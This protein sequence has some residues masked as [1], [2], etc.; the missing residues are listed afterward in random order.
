MMVSAGE[1]VR[2]RHNDAPR[3]VVTADDFGLSSTVNEGIVVASRR[4]IVRNTAL[5]VNFA[6]VAASVASLRDAGDLDVGIHLNLTSGPPVSKADQVPSLLGRGGTFPGLPGF[7]ARAALGRIR[8]G[9]VRREWE[10]QIEL[11]IRLGCRFTS[12]SGHQHVHMLPQLVGLTAMLARSYGI[13]VVRLSRYHTAGGIGPRRFKVWALLPCALAARRIFRR[14]GIL[15]NDY[16]LGISPVSA[17][18]A[19]A[20][21]C[22]AVRRLP[23]G[24]GELVCHPGYADSTLK[25]RDGY[26]AGRIVELDVLTAPQL[27][28]ALRSNGIEL[29]TFRDLAGGRGAGERPGVER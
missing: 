15:H 8:R 3:V 6:D 25:E 16:L 9:E 18:R 1:R 14:Q 28:A 27:G 23:D 13:P 17:E 12:I 20:G 10:A 2:G 29:T 21:L 5:L 22:A 4:G 24:L 26:T 19:L 11:G 7:L